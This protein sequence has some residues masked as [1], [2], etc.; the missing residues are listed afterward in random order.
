M[1]VL[2]SGVLSGRDHEEAALRSAKPL[3][4]FSRREPPPPARSKAPAN[5]R[6]LLLCSI[7]STSFQCSA[8]NTSALFGCRSRCALA[9]LVRRSCL[10]VNVRA[11]A[12]FQPSDAISCDSR[13]GSRVAQA[14]ARPGPPS[15]Q[16]PSK[17]RP[18]LHG[19]RAIGARGSQNALAARA[20]LRSVQ[21]AG[22]T[23]ARSRSQS[24]PCVFLLH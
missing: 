19:C 5:A 11:Q 9:A 21:L 7:H 3:V 18:S 16:K 24:H 4:T 10:F 12:D 22:D 13:G 20:S 14:M 17:L 6:T 15:D 2:S 8:H 23:R 1:G